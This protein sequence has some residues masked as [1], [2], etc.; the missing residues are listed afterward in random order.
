[1]CTATG[2]FC[3]SYFHQSVK[4]HLERLERFLLAA[5]VRSGIRRIAT[6]GIIKDL[7]SLAEILIKSKGL[8][9]YAHFPEKFVDDIYGFERSGWVVT[10]G[11]TKRY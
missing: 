5:R 2:N 10:T 11:L 8:G 9:Y 3:A 1:S 4:L 7:I 6:H